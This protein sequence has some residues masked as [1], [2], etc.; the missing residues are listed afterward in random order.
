MNNFLHRLIRG[1]KAAPPEPVL[2]A[3]DKHFSNA[4]NVEWFS[5]E[6]QYEAIFYLDRLEHIARFGQD[7]PLVEYKINLPA[8]S[9]P[10]EVMHAVR[11]KGEIMNAVA[12][13]AGGR[14]G[15]EIIYRDNKLKR[16]LI[17]VRPDGR[18][19]SEKPL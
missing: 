8:G 15:Y 1:N 7:G 4:L 5:R 13:H 14:T 6:N 17:L 12:I 10:L 9:I 16:F 19:E 3:L 18:I 2:R 11:A